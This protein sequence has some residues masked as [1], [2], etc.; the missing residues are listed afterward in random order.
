MPGNKAFDKP[1]VNASHKAESKKVALSLTERSAAGRSAMALEL[2][3]VIEKSALDAERQRQACRAVDE[4]CAKLG[5]GVHP[6]DGLRPPL[7]CAPCG[8]RTGGTHHFLCMAR[9][10]MPSQPERGVRTAVVSKLQAAWRAR[11]H[12]LQ[13]VRLLPRPIRPHRPTR[14]TLA[15]P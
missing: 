13:K 4:A 10:L 1:S 2:C 9:K 11:Q 8:G 6:L 14:P 7:S 5:R 3:T 15:C 12:A